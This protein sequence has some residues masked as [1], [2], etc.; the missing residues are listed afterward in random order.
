MD[1]EEYQPSSSDEEEEE[2]GEDDT[3][4]GIRNAR[5]RTNY[6]YRYDA[7]NQRDVARRNV[8]QDNWLLLHNSNKKR[9]C[10]IVLLYQMI[11][12]NQLTTTGRLVVYPILILY[13][14]HQQ[15][16][17]SAIERELEDLLL[18]RARD[19]VPNIFSE[20]RNRMI[21]QLSDESCY[22]WTRFS[23]E[24]L[25]LL[26]RHFRM[27][28][29]VRPAVSGG[30]RHFSGEEVLV[31]S[32][33]KIATGLSFLAMVNIFGGNPREYSSIFNWFIDYMFTTFY[34]KI[35]GRS[36]EYWIPHIEYFQS[37][38]HNRLSQ[39][40]SAAELAADPTL[41]F[42]QVLEVALELFRVWAFIDCTDMRTVR[43]GSG[44]QPD[45]SRRVNAHEIQLEF[46]SRYFRAHGL[47]FLSLLLPNGLVGTVFGAN[48]SQNDNGMINLSGLSDYLL[49]LLQPMPSHNLYPTVFGDSIM[50]LTPVIQ[51]YPRTDSARSRIWKRRMASARMSIELDYGLLFNNFRIMIK[52]NDHHLFN[53]GE[54]TFRLGIVCFFLKNCYV[55]L[56]GST[57]NTMFDV[58]P[59]T[60]EQY[61]PIDEEL[62][63]YIPIPFAEDYQFDYG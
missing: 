31:I 30:R 36:L 1:N 4:I 35:S 24:Q 3:I 54:H 50:Q 27:P 55:C 41:Q 12:I 20:R 58:D 7:L 29:I 44:P 6:R 23:K 43:P 16:R 25:H 21:N 56:N 32:L 40:P 13:L 33:T 15:A 11:R 51:S 60:L 59:P 63:E 61:L 18:I 38:I 2:E 34:H 26:F 48:L 14:C 19:R 10:I 46:Y 8:L 62:I 39:P 47:K 57:T 49:S 37:I 42:I 22:E 5:N 52:E 28:N 45:G 17:L 9:L 53:N